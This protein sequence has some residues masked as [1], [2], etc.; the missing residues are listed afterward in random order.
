MK[1]KWTASELRKLP[2]DERNAILAAAA[3]RAEEDYSDRHL[4]ATEALG[5]DDLFTESASDEKC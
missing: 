4:T 3:A 1:S 2:P 5:R